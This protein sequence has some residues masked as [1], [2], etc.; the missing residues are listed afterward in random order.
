MGARPEPG[1]VEAAT[2]ALAARER[3]RTMRVRL[4]WRYAGQRVEAAGPL[5]GGWGCRVPL[6]FCPHDRCWA[7]EVWV[8]AW[9][10]F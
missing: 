8:C 9:L 10:E 5:L 7:A 6:H 3:E 1:A 4:I 2:A